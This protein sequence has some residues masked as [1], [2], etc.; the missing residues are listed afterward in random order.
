MPG[1]KPL[2]AKEKTSNKLNPHSHKWRRRRDLNPSHIGGRRALS[3]SSPWLFPQK[4]GGGKALGTR[5]ERYRPC[6][7]PY[8][9]KGRR[10]IPPPPPPKGKEKPP[11]TQANIAVRF[12]STTCHSTTGVPQVNL[13][14]KT[15]ATRADASNGSKVT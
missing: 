10:K 7:I 4:M 8:F 5:L 12:P 15:Q 6:A 14:M 11:A 2:G 3:T 1:E 13:I 9:P